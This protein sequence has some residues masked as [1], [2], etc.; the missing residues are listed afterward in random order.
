MTGNHV[1]IGTRAWSWHA[2]AAEG[3]VDAPGQ[4]VLRQV[5]EVRIVKLLRQGP[6]LRLARAANH[7]QLHG[8]G[9]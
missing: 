8:C 4:P 7:E 6:H 5:L 2:R 9:T 1:S 3:S